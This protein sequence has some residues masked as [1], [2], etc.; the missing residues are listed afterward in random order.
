MKAVNLSLLPL[1]LGK[2]LIVSPDRKATDERADP[3]HGGRRVAA[4]E[5][6]K[7]AAAIRGR[8]LRC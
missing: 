5:N 3:K 6:P 8:M 1:L 2:L 4:T 7:C